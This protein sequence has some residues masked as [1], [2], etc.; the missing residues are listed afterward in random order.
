MNSVLLELAI[1]FALLVANGVFSMAE[2]AIVSSRKAKLRQLAADGDTRARL[3]L[4]LAES[5]NTFLA[6][7]QIGITLIGVLTAAFSGASISAELAV[8][9]RE[10]GW[11]ATY[12]DQIAFSLVVVVLTYFTLVIGE[13]VPKRIGLGNPEGVASVLA[14]PMH[15]LSRVG[16]PLVILLGRSTDALL[17]LLRIKPVAE[18]KVSEEEVRLLVREGMRVGLFHPQEPAMIESV[19]ALDHTPVR[20][21]MTPRAKIIWI[22]VTDS[23]ETIWHRIVVS[24]HSTF[25]V[26]EGK[27][28][29]VL[30]LVTVKAIYANLAAGVAVN[31]RDLTTPALVLPESL[32]TSALLDRFKTTGKHVALVTDEFGAIAGLVSLH[33]VIEAIVGEL[34]SPSDRLKPR[35]VRR[36]NGSWLVDGMLDAA[37][38]ERTVVDFPLHPAG[39]R[40]YQTFAGFIVKHLGHVPAEGESFRYHGYLVEVI[41]LDVHRVDKVLLIPARNLSNPLPA[42]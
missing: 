22:N 9:L 11:L 26:Y 18:V 25:P 37:E 15:G 13:L 6:T 34:P 5:P 19:M 29:N 32:S 30:G 41:D 14:G 20:D 7:V 36:D 10:I 35:A 23:H 4:H 40:D 17:R 24:A 28:D 3:A 16:A 27:R 31:V 2:I 38:F 1:V 21:L 39:A 8:P 33:D 12:A 42:V